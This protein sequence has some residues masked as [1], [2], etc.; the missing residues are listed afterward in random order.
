ML[1]HSPQRVMSLL[2]EPGTY[3]VSIR[4]KLNNQRPSPTM[5]F[6]WR[7]PFFLL[8]VIPS[9]S[10]RSPHL[11]PVFIL[12]VISFPCLGRIGQCPFYS[13][14]G[15]STSHDNSSI[16]GCKTLCV[17]HQEGGD[18]ILI[19]QALCQLCSGKKKTKET[20]LCFPSGNK[21]LRTE[22]QW[23]HFILLRNQ[24][25]KPEV[26][27]PTCPCEWGGRG[28]NSISCMTSF[29]FTCLDTS[30]FLPYPDCKCLESRVLLGI[31]LP[32]A[33]WPPF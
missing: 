9:C 32:T 24:S 10:F 27:I 22:R 16:L 7:N 29:H 30:L 19:M 17:Y 28:L 15:V 2:C 6:L 33:S 1:C 25:L 13:S 18:I 5:P 11:L 14:A 31:S 20:Q 3:E 21:Q 4:E 26:F 23:F 8:A 12:P